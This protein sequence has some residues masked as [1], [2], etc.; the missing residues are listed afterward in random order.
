[1]LRSRATASGDIEDGGTRN[2]DLCLDLL[3]LVSVTSLLLFPA[4]YA[5]VQNLVTFII[6]DGSA[7]FA[8]RFVV[9]F[10]YFLFNVEQ[11][12]KVGKPT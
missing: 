12:N 7:R 11:N 8:Y 6:L 3:G 10:L 4:A 1:M 2:N 5:S 9:L